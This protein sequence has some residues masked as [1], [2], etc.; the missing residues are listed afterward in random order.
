MNTPQ[1]DAGGTLNYI[2]FADVPRVFLDE[3]GHKLADYSVAIGKVTQENPLRFRVFASG[4]LVH[5]GNRYG[6]LT[7]HH[8]VNPPHSPDFHFGSVDGDKLML[9]L[10]RGNFS[11]L[12]SEILI[13]H[14]LG[15]PTGENDEPDLAFI[16]IL[17]SPQLD[18]IKA[19]SSF[20]S[21]DRDWWTIRKE[22]GQLETPFTVNGFPGE[23]H[24]TEDDG[25]ITRK[26]YRHM[27][28]FYAIRSDGIFP[29]QDW[30]YLEAVNRYDSGNELPL[31]FEGVS[32]GAAWGLKIQQNKSTG[33][34]V[35]QDF[36][37]IGIA[38][39]QIPIS[40]EELRVRIHFIRS[41]YDVAWQNF[42]PKMG[43]LPP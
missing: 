32:G 31:S 28:F 5:K 2:P 24:D 16:E 26:I 1:T 12:S 34:F 33:K 18:S 43:D 8:C 42:T 23:Y 10:R 6:V 39:S 35:L 11:V 15:I 13:R 14:N 20:W 30:D 38:I 3:V 36:C 7:A 25:N 37:L 22:F 29:G 9:L 4:V 17:K 27:A 40:Q 21:L 19:I 41:I